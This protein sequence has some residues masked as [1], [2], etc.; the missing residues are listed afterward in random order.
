MARYISGRR[1][2][3]RGNRSAAAPLPSTIKYNSY[4]GEGTTDANGFANIP[5]TPAHSYLSGVIAVS[6][7]PGQTGFGIGASG[8]DVNV[9]PYQFGLN[10]DTSAQYPSTFYIVTDRPIYRPGDTVQFRGI[11]RQQN[12][13]R[14]LLPERDTLTLPVISYN[15]YEGSTVEDLPVLDLD[16]DTNGNFSGEFV[17]GEEWPLGTYAIASNQ[18]D[19][20]GERSFTV[21]EYR[22]PEFLV[23]VTPATTDVQRGETVDVT[24]EA[25]YFFGGSVTDSQVNWN[26]LAERYFLPWDLTTASPMMIISSSTMIPSTPPAERNMC[27]VE[28]ARLMPK[29]N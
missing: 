9:N 13:G 11:L 25:S 4:I 7:A 12:Y 17:I 1:I 19:L 15:Y 26:V 5:Y 22:A 29:G 10:T 16:V 24:I 18:G 8:W 6:N 27:W 28:K 14:Y 2:W 21:A 3:R 20:L 23:S